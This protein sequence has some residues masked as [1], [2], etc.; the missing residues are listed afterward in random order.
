LSTGVSVINCEVVALL[1]TI[2]NNTACAN[3]NGIATGM[4][5]KGINVPIVTTGSNSVE[6]G[7]NSTDGDRWR[8]R[9]TVAADHERRASL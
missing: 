8:P 2:N 6:V 5:G 4:K 7:M 9:Y 3:N 1:T